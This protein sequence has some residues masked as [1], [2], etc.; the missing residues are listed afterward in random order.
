MKRIELTR[1]Q[2]K[3]L[4]AVG[5]CLLMI[6][7]GFVGLPFALLFFGVKK[8]IADMSSVVVCGLCY[9]VIR[10]R[11][12]FVEYTLPDVAQAVLRRLGYEVAYAVDD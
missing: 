2:F 9:A 6:F 3:V 5:F 11:P 7:L 1:R 10:R 12:S 8:P 4:V